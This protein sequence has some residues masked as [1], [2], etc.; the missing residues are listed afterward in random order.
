MAS[1]EH[2]YHEACAAL[3]AHVDA[4][5]PLL[6]ELE[7]VATHRDCPQPIARVLREMERQARSMQR[8]A[9]ELL[10]ME[11]PTWERWGQVR[12]FVENWGPTLDSI[13]HLVNHLRAQLEL[14]ASLCRH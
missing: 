2:D 11:A 14:Q 10:A 5:A 12:V 7:E 9:E 4:L 1:L 6:R 8:S 13:A 3:A